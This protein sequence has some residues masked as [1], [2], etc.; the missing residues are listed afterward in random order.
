MRKGALSFL[1]RYRNLK[2]SRSSRAGEQKEKMSWSLM[3]TWLLPSRLRCSSRGRKFFLT[4]KIS[5]KSLRN[6][7]IVNFF[8][9]SAKDKGSTF[10][11]IQGRTLGNSFPLRLW[12]AYVTGTKKAPSVGA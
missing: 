3:F 5:G 2:L 10:L 7:G 9:G 11:E 6:L 1:P 8:Q 12:T 4:R